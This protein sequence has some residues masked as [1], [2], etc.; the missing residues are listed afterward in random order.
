MT[1]VSGRSFLVDDD[2]TE[3]M[4]DPARQGEAEWRAGRWSSK[5]GAGVWSGI[6]AE[7][8]VV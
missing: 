2:G 6:A 4:A 7:S 3:Y 8:L 1:D 5:R